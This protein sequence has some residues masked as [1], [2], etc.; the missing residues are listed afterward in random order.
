HTSALLPLITPNFADCAACFAPIQ[1]RYVLRYDNRHF[2]S[3]C[4]RCSMCHVEL[5]DE[6]PPVYGRDGMLFCKAD[7]DSY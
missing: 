4:L 5:A 2:H 1:D 7:F 3:S 6:Q